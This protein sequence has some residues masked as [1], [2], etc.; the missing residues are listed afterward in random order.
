ML[1]EE[2]WPDGYA[3]RVRIGLH[4]GE[5][6]LRGDSYVG[7][8]VHRAARIAAAGRGGQVLLSTTSRAL[9]EPELPEGVLV[10]DLGEHR[11]KDLDQPEHLAQL[12]IA[13]LDRDFPA[14]RTVESPSNLPE[15]LTTFVG[16]QREVD[17][18]SEL[19][20]TTRLLTL[21]GPGGTGKTRLALRIATRVRPAYR[22]GVFF[23]DLAPLSDPK[24]VGPAVARSL[25]LSDQGGRCAARSR[26]TLSRPMWRS[27]TSTTWAS[28]GGTPTMRDDGA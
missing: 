3:V 17:E 13:G 27:T 16:R 4:T 20:A 8:D 10:R 2:R 6:R 1:A 15:E 9:V 18:A 25:G 28:S 5:G 23:V 12:I 14:I 26:P 21:T 22:D 24:L 11:L 19:L 7:L